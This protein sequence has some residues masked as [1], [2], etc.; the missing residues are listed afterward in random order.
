M[1]RTW[2]WIFVIVG[3]L[4]LTAAVARHFNRVSEQAT[5][6]ETSGRV[7]DVREGCITVEFMTQAQR[8]VEFTGSV[9]Q[10][11]PVFARGEPVSVLYA[12]QD[13]ARASINTFAQNWFVS[14]FFAGMGLISSLVGGVCVWFITLAPGR[15]ERRAQEL[16]RIGK[17]I[18][19]RV[20]GVEPNVALSINGRHPWRIVAQWLD[21]TSRKVRLFYSQNLWFDPTPYLTTKELQVWVDPD[22]PN[23][24]SVDTDFLPKMD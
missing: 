23:R 20:M 1:K 19:A 4:M 13:P 5:M 3:V 15:A 8:R 12:P 11:P 9:C 6:V 24:Y 18:Q 7:V 10:K 17:S 21:P 14:L 16:K 22:R 2:P